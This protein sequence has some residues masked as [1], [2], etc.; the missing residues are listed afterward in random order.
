VTAERERSAKFAPSLTNVLLLLRN[1]NLEQYKHKD[2]IITRHSKKCLRM[3][4]IQRSPEVVL[5]ATGVPGL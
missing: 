3:K 2:K 1:I 5:E 4:G